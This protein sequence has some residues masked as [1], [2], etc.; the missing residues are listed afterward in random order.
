MKQGLAT[1]E[2]CNSDANEN[3]FTAEVRWPGMRADVIPAGRANRQRFGS[4]VRGEGRDWFRR[5]A[6]QF[7]EG[8]RQV[9]CL[10]FGC[11]I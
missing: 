9:A 6:N 8:A 2:E 5:E 1:E 3:W 11:V 4:L 10:W 7:Q